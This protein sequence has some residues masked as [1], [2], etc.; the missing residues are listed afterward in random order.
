MAVSVFERVH[1]IRK[2]K[3]FV[4]AVQRWSVALP[5]RYDRYFVSFCGVQSADAALVYGSGFFPGSKQR[6]PCPPLLSR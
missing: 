3:D 1:P 2:P 4:P 6:S 5:N